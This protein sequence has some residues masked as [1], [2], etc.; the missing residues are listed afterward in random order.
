M[1]DTIR[2][3]IFMLKSLSSMIIP[4]TRLDGKTLVSA[5]H[6]SSLPVRNYL[7]LKSEMGGGAEA[8]VIWLLGLLCL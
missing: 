6:E 4:V 1:T 3:I 2:E 8:C 5:A 7:Y